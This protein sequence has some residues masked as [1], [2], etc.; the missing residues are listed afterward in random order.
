[1]SVAVLTSAAA[2]VPM[3][4]HAASVTERAVSPP[5]G[6]GRAIL[7][8]QGTS[9]AGQAAQGREAHRRADRCSA[10]GAR[11]IPASRSPPG[12]LHRRGSSFPFGKSAR[13]AP[14]PFVGTLPETAATLQV[15]RAET[16]EATKSVIPSAFAVAGRAAVA[17]SP[18]AAAQ[19]M[20]IPAAVT[21]A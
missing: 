10:E 3:V 21:L 12:S 14:D 9:A 7:A 6:A 16:V 5:W 1:G 17:R 20:V 18:A 11:A 19:A 8:D 4:E 2:A 15:E 13:G